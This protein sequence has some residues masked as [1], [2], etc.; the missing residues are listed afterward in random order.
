M[1]WVTVCCVL[2][3]VAMYVRYRQVA[4][5]LSSSES[6]HPA[7]INKA[8]LGVGIAVLFGMTLVANFPVCLIKWSTIKQWQLLLQLLTHSFCA[9]SSPAHSAWM[10]S[11]ATDVTHLCVVGHTR[12]VMEPAKI[13]ISWMRISCEKSVGCGC[14][15]RHV[16]RSYG[17]A[18]QKQLNRWRCCLTHVGQRKHVLDGVT[19]GRICLQL[20]GMMMVMRPFAKLL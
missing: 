12:D 13:R 14:G 7:R 6:P 10:R 19:I 8:A 2:V 4:E 16:P 20:R 3:G 18:V 17:C 1:K 9:A 5:H 11:C 15:I